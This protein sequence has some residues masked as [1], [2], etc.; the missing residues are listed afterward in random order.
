MTRIALSFPR[1]PLAHA[2]GSVTE[3]DR[4]GVRQRI[5][6]SLRRGATVRAAAA[7]VGVSYEMAELIVDEM[8]RQGLLT[9]ASSLCSSGLGVCSGGDTKEARLHCAGCPLVI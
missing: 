4:R 2:A 6:L 1:M 3:A 8:K 7:E 9:S 5:F